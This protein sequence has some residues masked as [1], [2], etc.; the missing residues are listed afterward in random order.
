ME[1]RRASPDMAAPG[2][3]ARGMPASAGWREGRKP[4]P[5]WQSDRLV[6]VLIL[7]PGAV[8]RGAKGPACSWLYSSRQPARLGGASWMGRNLTAGAGPWP[9]AAGRE[10]VRGHRIRG[11]AGLGAGEGEQ[12]SAGGGRAVHRGLRGA[13]GGQPL[14]RLEPDVVGNV[15]PAD[16]EGGGDPQGR[17][18]HQD[19]RGADDRRPRCADRGREPDGNR[20]GKVLPRGLLRLPAGPRG[21]RCARRRAQALLGV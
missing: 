5:G 12:G 9:G 6:V 20:D 8:G 14:P 15:V 19:A 18:R 10:A 2:G 4:L 17:G 3:V 7:L 13:A 16:G 11:L 21:A 1:R